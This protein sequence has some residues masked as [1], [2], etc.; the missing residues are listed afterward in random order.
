MHARRVS[1][2]IR[3]GRSSQTPQQLNRLREFGG[4]ATG[5]GR[6][7]ADPPAIAPLLERA[8]DRC[9]VDVTGAE[10]RRATAARE[11]ASHRVG[12]MHVAD[13]PRQL[14]DRL[15]AAILASSRSASA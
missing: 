3:D 10:H 7:D 1:E 5:V 6:L 11:A 13:V 12:G 2:G 9:K 14:F 4:T 15:V 8:E